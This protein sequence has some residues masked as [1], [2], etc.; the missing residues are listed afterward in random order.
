MNAHNNDRC[1][2]DACLEDLGEEI[3][4]KEKEDQVVIMEDIN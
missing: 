2:C 1:P 3:K 4:W